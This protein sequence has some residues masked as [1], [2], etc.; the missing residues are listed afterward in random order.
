MVASRSLWT[1]ND[2][3]VVR[4]VW[5]AVYL[6]QTKRKNKDGTAAHYLELADNVRDP[7]SGVV[8]AQILHSLG[9][10]EHLEREAFEQFVASIARYL[11]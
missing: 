7:D 4:L 1:Q 9:R 5:A 2:D 10:A 3:G 8:K 6:R 11:D